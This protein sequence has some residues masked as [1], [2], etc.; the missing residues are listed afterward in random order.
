MKK[1]KRARRPLRLDLRICMQ[2]S[3]FVSRSMI[4]THN[5]DK[6]SWLT[7]LSTRTSQGAPSGSYKIAK[8]RHG[9]ES[10]EK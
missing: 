9:G 1:G 6:R 8:M 4:P 5:C 7:R 10:L 3:F 2:P